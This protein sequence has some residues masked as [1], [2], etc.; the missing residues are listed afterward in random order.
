MKD[1]F[2]FWT[3][4]AKS[5]DFVTGSLTGGTN[6][7]NDDVEDA[8]EIDIIERRRPRNGMKRSKMAN[9]QTMASSRPVVFFI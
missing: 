4:Q 8:A 2:G 5:R 7:G 9:H 3:S 1:V 6:V